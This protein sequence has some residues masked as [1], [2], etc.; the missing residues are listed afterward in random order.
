[1]KTKLKGGLETI[2]AAI[3]IISIVVAIIWAVVVPMADDGNK[4]LRVTT[5]GLATHQ[6]TIGPSVNN[7]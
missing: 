2:M 6:A 7:P 1:M 5:N 4:L 3:I